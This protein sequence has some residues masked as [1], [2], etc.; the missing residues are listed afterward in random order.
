M[1]RII[2]QITG[3]VALILLAGLVVAGASYTVSLTPAGSALQSLVRRGGGGPPPGVIPGGNATAAGSAVPVGGAAAAGA[4]A[5]RRG[6]ANG[7]MPGSGT[8]AAGAN[9]GSG[10]PAG[11][12]FPAG[13]GGG[14]RPG[15][16]GGRPADP[17]RGLPEFGRDLATLAG[18]VLVAVLLGKV[19]TRLAAM[20]RGRRHPVAT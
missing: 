15:G 10:A 17:S 18:I 2:G 3:R 12:T 5:G 19:L 1:G 7:V 9:A 8:A 16:S 20:M 13:P 4:N 6:P 14:A 11:G